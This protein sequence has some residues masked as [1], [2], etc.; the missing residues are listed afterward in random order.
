MQVT[1][2]QWVLCE[3]Q[4]L[5]TLQGNRDLTTTTVWN[6]CSQSIFVGAKLLFAQVLEKQEKQPVIQE[7]ITYIRSV[8]FKQ[9]GKPTYHEC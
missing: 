2:I 9:E 5:K 1:I 6:N 7:T 3:R 4:G 8:L